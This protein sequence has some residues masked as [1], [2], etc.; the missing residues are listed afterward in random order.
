MSLNL[1][2]QAGLFS[3]LILLAASGLWINRQQD[4]LTNLQKIN[5]LQNQQLKA[6][7]LQMENIKQRESRLSTALTARQ[8]TQQRLEEN[9]EQHQQKLH[10]V[11]AQVPCAAQ[12]VPDDVIRL[13]RNALRG[14]A[15]SR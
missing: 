15:F 14:D 10:R 6:L 11:L 7:Q 8:Q 5:I 1:M 4:R 12:P 13:Q 9:N 3:L 2:K